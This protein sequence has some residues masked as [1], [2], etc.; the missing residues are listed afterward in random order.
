L[1]PRLATLGNG[2][3]PDK[4]RKRG[5]TPGATRDVPLGHGSLGSAEPIVN[6]ERE[7][8][9]IEALGG[10]RP[11][12]RARLSC[13]RSAQRVVDGSIAVSVAAHRFLVIACSYRTIRLGFLA[14]RATERV[15][16][17][18]RSHVVS[19]GCETFG[20]LR[21]GEPIR[22]EAALD[23]VTYRAA[24]AR[25]L[26]RG[27]GFAFAKHTARLGQRQFLRIVTSEAQPIACIESG[28][29]LAERPLELRSAVGSVG[30]RCLN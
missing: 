30:F 10:R 5:L 2:S 15:G 28:Q 29:R 26:T 18:K 4:R 20:D 22:T 14:R 11:G 25:Q 6:P 27:G 23:A 13:A 16:Q 3:R 1:P 7:R 24:S 19:D 9:R 8:F 21:L 17:V 12:R